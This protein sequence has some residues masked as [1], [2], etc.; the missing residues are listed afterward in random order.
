MKPNPK[1]PVPAGF[2]IVELLITVT[3]MILL[4]G[5]IVGGFAFV[6]DRQA[7]DT[8][9]VQIALLSRGL[10][11]YRLDMGVYPG[12]STE[13]GEDAFGGD[14]TSAN[15]ENSQVLYRALFYQ[16]WD[17]VE[18]DRPN[19]WPSHA[20]TKIFLSELDPNDGSQGWLDRI[21]G[22]TPPDN[23][24]IIDPWGNPYRYRVG[25][26][27]MNPDFD[28]WSTGKDGL[29][30]PGASGSPYDPKAPENVDDIRNF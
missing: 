20:A 19:G 18:Q 10:D 11:E 15:G 1:K 30:V 8:A 16:G 28:L 12:A 29:T 21:T 17:F 2:T 3:I 23:L 9:K 5:M 13:L 14:A 22:S 25:D 24:R 26:H 27:A 7:R 6:R 4:A